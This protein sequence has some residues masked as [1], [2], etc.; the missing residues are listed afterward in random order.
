MVQWH[1]EETLISRKFRAIHF[2]RRR[3]KTLCSNNN[4]KSFHVSP[5]TKIALSAMN[6]LRKKSLTQIEKV[7]NRKNLIIAAVMAI[8]LSVG[9]I[10]AAFG[11]VITSNHNTIASWTLLECN[12]DYEKEVDA[13]YGWPAHAE[14]RTTAF[15]GGVAPYPVVVIYPPPPAWLDLKSGGQ[16][17]EWLDTLSGTIDCLVNLEG[18]PTEDYRDYA[19]IE[20]NNYSLGL[21]LLILGIVVIPLL[22]GTALGIVVYVVGKRKIDKGLPYT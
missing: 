22:S 17:T 12:F 16:L 13:N 14:V 10:L 4:N 11:S 2:E 6:A 21:A 15:S 18:E 9:V 7:M 20:N 19:V 8:P 1:L 5:I 3:L